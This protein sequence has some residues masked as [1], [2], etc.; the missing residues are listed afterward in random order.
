MILIS[1]FVTDEMS[2]DTFHTDSDQIHVIG[3]ESSFGGAISKSMITAF[4]V[5]ETSVQEIQ[6]IEMAV[7]ITNPYSGK[8]KS[9]SNNLFATEK[10]VI[11]ASPDFFSLFNFPLI[12]GDPV[13]ALEKP[14]TVVI[15][16]KIAEKYFPNEDPIGKIL[17]IDRYEIAEY[18]VTGVA[19]NIK[20]NSYLNFD[21]VFS[22]GGLT[23]TKR[24]LDSWGA[25]MY[26]TF[27]RINENSTPKDIDQTVNDA[28]DVHL[29]E[30]RAA[31]VNYFFIP[32]SE[33]YLSELVTPNGFKGSYMYIYIFSAIAF[34]V[35][36]LASINYMNLSTARGLQRGKEVG[37]RKVLGA[38][39]LQLVQQF[40]GE[41]IMF[42]FIALIFAFI[43]AEVALPAFN[44]VFEKELVFNFFERP[45]FILS[46]VA[47]AIGI[48][49][50]SGFY[51][52]L[53]LSRFKP[54]GILKGSST[55][56]IGGISLR[57]I[58]V[59]FQF[60]ISTVL[61]IGTL[62]VLSQLNFLLDKDLGFN[63]EQTLFISFNDAS[64]ISIYKEAIEKHQAV[65]STST[66]NGVP[67][68]FYF[69]SS[70][71]FDPERPDE[72]IAT[73]VIATDDNYDDV[74]GLTILAGSYF[75][76]EK[77][78]ELENSI[79]INEAMQKRMN[80]ST[81][82]D[83][84]GKEFANGDQI[85]G[86][87]NDFHFRTLRTEISP[88][89]INSIHAQNSSF[90]GTDMLV[91]KFRA[92]QTRELIDFLQAS[93]KSMVSNTPVTYTFL[94][95]TMDKL[96]ETDKK[97]GNV[98]SLFAGVGI[99]IACMGLFGLTAFSAERKTKEIGI[100][101][102]LGATVLNIVSLLSLDFL[103]LVAIGFVIA[104][105]ISWY[106]MNTWLAEFAYRIDIG[107]EIFLTAGTLALII[108]FIT[109]SW[110]SVKAASSNPVD[111]L[112][113]E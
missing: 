31:G 46:I 77:I 95:E 87:V 93:W 65:I 29:G 16:E 82:N 17:T 40:L 81:P 111:S 26:N 60:S 55:S 33:L 80:W 100:R 66:A 109:T 54:A 76:D 35:L 5:A 11:A 91:V 62:V 107:I 6:E 57:K 83:A 52:A 7:V 71:N 68:N 69:S 15:T 47:L 42:S 90:S 85:I 84:I 3:V 67:G 24:N 25:S 27:V 79:I 51:P 41:A 105:P 86:V 32:I 75:D 72:Q 10:K 92:E 43:L 19:K 61:V 20:Q 106:T 63:K 49:I 112:K 44:G 96:Y 4:P 8:V 2:F 23:S 108:A 102:V 9:S 48:G 18:V 37:V 73:H 21:I 99:F 78:S 30:R 1:L 34:F 50:I 89:V 38:N 56:E 28:F 39:K 104:A 70:D 101:K 97:L 45:I 22:I 59:V 36:L 88:V 64:K 14:N 58:L 113:N 98:F 94:D 53:F 74:L 12:K 13:T 110:Q 103:K